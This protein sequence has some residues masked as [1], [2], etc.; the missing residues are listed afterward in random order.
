MPALDYQILK[1]KFRELKSAKLSAVVVSKETADIESQVFQKQIMLFTRQLAVL[2]RSGMALVPALS[3]LAQQFK[4]SSLHAVVVRIRDD[5]NAGQNFAEALSVFPKLFSDV[6]INMVA[7]GQLSGNLEEILLRLSRMQHNRAQLRSKVRAA[8]AYPLMMIVV[9]IG[10]LTFLLAYVVPSITSIFNEI[11]Q[12]LPRPTVFL[13]TASEF[14]KANWFWA[15]V[16]LIVVLAGLKAWRKTPAGA[17]IGDTILLKTPLIGTLLMKVE[18]ARFAS[19]LAVLLQSGVAML[20]ALKA[21]K[22]IAR[23]TLIKESLDQ[24]HDAV[25]RGDDLASALGRTGR[26]DPL[27]YHILSTGQTT[28]TLE[29]ALSEIAQ[30]NDQDLR[31]QTQILTALL[32]PA[33]L[34]VMGL[35]VGFI[36]TAIL[37]PIIEINQSF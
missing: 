36:V 29:N 19:T 28:A 11:D 12:A 20:D 15:M 17:R 10:V 32:E 26:F 27:V 31:Q 7:A 13:I 9:A 21:A 35:I 37:L 33:I 14:I 2:L 30:L 25:S 34:L 18:L 6:Y 4:G 3:A 5:I 8:I 1:E 24:I 22:A 23:N 16:L